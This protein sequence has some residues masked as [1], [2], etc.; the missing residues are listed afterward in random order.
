MAYPYRNSNT[1][2]KEETRNQDSNPKELMQNAS[3]QPQSEELQ[4]ALA[5][6]QKQDAALAKLTLQKSVLEEE[7]AFLRG[8]LKV[9]EEIQISAADMEQAVRDHREIAEL[10]RDD[11]VCWS[12][13]MG[14][15][16][17]NLLYREERKA[18]D[19]MREEFSQSQEWRKKEM[20]RVGSQVDAM[21]D[22]LNRG[23]RRCERIKRFVLLS[24]VYHTAFLMLWILKIA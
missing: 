13:E 21:S 16:M 15:E 14:N 23:V 1:P 4:K 9:I 7:N 19:A 3:T 20:E 12:E 11:F 18:L 8:Q 6:I 17:L 5:L 22:R 24:V 2:R 10:F